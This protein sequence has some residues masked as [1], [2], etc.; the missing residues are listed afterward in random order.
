MIIS[1]RALLLGLI[2]LC[3]TALL[4]AG[5]VWKQK[6]FSQWS[7]KDIQGIFQDSPWAHLVAVPGVK[8]LSTPNI[9]TSDISGTKP[10]TGGEESQ[11]I[12]MQAQFLVQWASALTLRQA[13]LRQLQLQG[14]A[15]DAAAAQ[16]L[17]QT[18]PQHVIVI[19]G[20]DLSPFEQLKGEE[21]QKGS[22]L[23]LKT[24]K[25]RVPAA[26]VQFFRQES[27]LTGVE[28]FF[29]REI[30]GKPA[31]APTENKVTFHCDLSATKIEADFDL[32]KMARDGKPDL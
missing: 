27:R 23:E 22:Y 11:G 32:R 14:L 5:E 8:R 9:A 26:G 4:L 30:E 31:I 18:P 1:K 17:S 19:L 2:L 10:M 3:S 13:R 28:F 15:S 20:A 7:D 12:P 21:V 16:L 6:P 25:Q 29:P 24:S